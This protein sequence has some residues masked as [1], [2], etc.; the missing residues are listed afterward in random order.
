MIINF[1]KFTTIF[2]L[3]FIVFVIFYKL[4]KQWTTGPFIIKINEDKY[5]YTPVLTK[6]GVQITNDYKKA[7]KF[8]DEYWAHSIS[9]NI[10]NSTVFEYKYIKYLKT[11]KW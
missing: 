4:Y 2:L 3:L 1:W 11:G 10:P 8:W 6:N 7:Y 5:L 9:E